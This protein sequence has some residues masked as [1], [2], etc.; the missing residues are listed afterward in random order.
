M[1]CQQANGTWLRRRWLGMV[2]LAVLWYGAAD[3]YGGRLA[4]GKLYVV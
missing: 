3:I 4:V 1:G 2:W